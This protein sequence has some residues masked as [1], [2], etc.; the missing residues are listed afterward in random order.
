MAL[1]LLPTLEHLQDLFI[2]DLQDVG[3]CC[4]ASIRL[5]SC[6]P[7]LAP[8]RRRRIYI[9]IAGLATSRGSAIALNNIKH[10]G[11]HQV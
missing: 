4:E 7:S 2:H 8:K 10:L 3:R 6:G 5:T 1:S 9:E 11:A